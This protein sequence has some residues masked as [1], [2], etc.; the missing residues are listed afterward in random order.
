MSDDLVN[1]D[2]RINVYVLSLISSILYL[3]DIIYL[4]E[5][6]EKY[7]QSMLSQ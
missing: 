6:V 1:S 4:C 5:L 3:H 7:G 2:T